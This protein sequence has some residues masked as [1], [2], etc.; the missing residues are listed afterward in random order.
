MNDTWTGAKEAWQSAGA[1]D[2]D[3][4]SD[5]CFWTRSS[6]GWRAGVA[7]EYVRGDAGNLAGGFR[8]EYGRGAIGLLGFLVSHQ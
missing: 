4:R 5:P 1:K 3:G 6:L 8:E 7:A 2:S